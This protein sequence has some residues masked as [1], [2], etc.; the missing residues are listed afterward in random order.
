MFWHHLGLPIESPEREAPGNRG[1]PPRVAAERHRSAAEVAA[2]AR[3]LT[4]N[5]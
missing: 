4:K 2:H 1:A 3:V 5:D